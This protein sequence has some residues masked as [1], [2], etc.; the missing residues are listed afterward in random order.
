L[1]GLRAVSICL[2]VARHLQFFFHGGWLHTRWDYGTFGVF[3]FFVISG[4]IITRLL[5]AERRRTGDISLRAFYWRRAF[6]ILPP[7]LL[8]LF[9]VYALTLCGLTESSLRSVILSLTFTRNYWPGGFASLGHLWSLSV[10][11]QFYI[12][13]PFLLKRLSDRS[14]S[15]VLLAVIFAA[16]VVR[17]VY[18]LT[19]AGGVALTWHFES[20]ADGLAFGCL[21]AINQEKLHANLS[22]MRFCTSKWTLWVLPCVMVAA[23][24]QRSHLR[25]EVLGKSLIFLSVALFLDVAIQ[26]Y[27]SIPGKILNS[28]PLVL[29]GRW[30][31]SLYL[32]QEIFL[33]V[34]RGTKPYAYFPLNLALSL[35]A[36]ITSYYLV[37]Q[38]SIRWGRALLN[39]KKPQI[40]NA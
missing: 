13:W 9:G 27:A 23:S 8:F 32:W 7:L 21:L 14:A 25:Y 40:A 3:V 37:E 39:R 35:S 5:V 4:Y 15:K 18:V 38:P 30:S 16:P 10:E 36:A 12:V 22:Y 20:V 2:V 1:D 34:L 28:R 26:Q 19:G 31:Y 24:S 29:L 33:L 17:L 11:E 6:R